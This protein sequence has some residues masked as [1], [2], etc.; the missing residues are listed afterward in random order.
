MRILS[1]CTEFPGPDTPH[2][3]LFIRRRLRALAAIEDV[4]FAHLRP[5]FPVVRP[6]HAHDAGADDGPLRVVRQPM[7]YIPGILK[8]LDG[9]WAAQA[10]RTAA[11]A[12][13]AEQRIDVVDAHF[14]YPE[15]VGCVRVAMELDRPV[16]IT[17]RGL[18][19]QILD[20]PWRARQLLHAL[21]RCDGI[22]C[23]SQSLYDLAV[24]NGID[25]SKVRVIPNAVERDIFCPG[26][27]EEARQRLGLD[28]HSRLIVSVGMFEFRKGQHLLL[29]AFSNMRSKH[30]ELRLAL[31]GGRTHERSYPDQI[32]RMVGEL[33][34]ADSV[35]MPGPQPPSR[36]ADWL[37]AA[38]LFALPTYDE[39]C[40]NAVLE[41]LACGV[42]VITTDVGD[43][44]PQIDAPRRGLLIPPGDANSL[45]E[46]I[47]TGLDRGW[48]RATIAH[49]GSDYTWDEVARRT[50]AFLHERLG[51]PV[52]ART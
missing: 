27:Q 28:T 22:V 52:A 41:A 32:D 20:H 43:N 5:W 6:L 21:H 3:G 4:T 45:T 16:F 36:V 39:G 25:A 8:G 31:V 2:R 35:F 17:M 11:R 46:A 42:P 48:D 40:C 18:E 34:L 50:S 12:L 23:V 19:R 33:G 47:A 26:S 15:G 29:E 13:D 1:V 24:E 14:G 49:F 10:V 7:F 9:H 51:S 38:D 44:A 37:R 30:P